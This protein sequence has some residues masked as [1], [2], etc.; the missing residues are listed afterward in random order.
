MAFTCVSETGVRGF[1]LRRASTRN[2]GAERGVCGRRRIRIESRSC[3][4]VAAPTECV[5]VS[6]FPGGAGPRFTLARKKFGSVKRRLWTFFDSRWRNGRLQKP[7]PLPA[8][9][10]GHPEN[11]FV[12]HRV[13][14]LHIK[15]SKV[16]RSRPSRTWRTRCTFRSR[17]KEGFG[18]FTR[19][20]FAGEKSCT[21]RID[22]AGGPSFSASAT[23]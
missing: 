16:F 2:C 11:L 20:K 3:T 12:D 7:H 10:I 4:D 17:H 15:V 19:T 18:K 14:R 8:Q 23:Q 13:R 5:H 22:L 6:S 1:A 21:V 9:R